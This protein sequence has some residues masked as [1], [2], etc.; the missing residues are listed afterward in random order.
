MQAPLRPN[1]FRE[2][3]PTSTHLDRHCAFPKVNA[4]C[5]MRTRSLPLRVPSAIKV[6]HSMTSQ[7]AR[8]GMLSV[9]PLPTM[10]T[11][12][13]WLTVNSGELRFAL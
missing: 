9:L 6:T 8:E 4:A 10:R 1:V 7:L 11:R 2:T 5:S 3:R 12:V 13:G